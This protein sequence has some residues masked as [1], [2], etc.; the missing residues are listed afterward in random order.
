MLDVR[1]LLSGSWITVM[2]IYLVGDVLRIY[3]GDWGRMSQGEQP[4]PNKWLFAALFMLV[5]I[6]MVF[7][8]L[9]IPQPINRWM[10]IILA[11]VFFLFVLVDIRSYPS[12]Y[13]RFLLAV[14]LIFNGVTFYLA[15]NW[16]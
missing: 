15:W 1:I 3:S 5:P 12:H 14:S 2:L 10:N 8:S 7:L 16:L 9:V 13:D 6:L 4:N 11:T